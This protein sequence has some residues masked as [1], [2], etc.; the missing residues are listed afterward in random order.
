MD[1]RIVKGR[2]YVLFYRFWI[3]EQI[4]TVQFVAKDEKNC[5]EKKKV[6]YKEYKETIIPSQRVCSFKKSRSILYESQKNM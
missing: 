3:N 1:S 4:K 6:Q 5:P 2:K